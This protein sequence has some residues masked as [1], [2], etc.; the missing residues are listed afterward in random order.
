MKLS[1]PHLPK[2]MVPLVALAHKLEAEI[3]LLLLVQLAD[4]KQQNCCLTYICI[5][6]LSLLILYL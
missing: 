5:S 2:P 4:L 3:V 1:P 6:F